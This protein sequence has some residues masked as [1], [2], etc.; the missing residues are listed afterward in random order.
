MCLR[1]WRSQADG[2]ASVALGVTK[3]C[4]FISL[5]CFPGFPGPHIQVQV[6]GQA[7]AIF[8]ETPP[9]AIVVLFALHFEGFAQIPCFVIAGPDGTMG[10]TRFPE[11]AK[12]ACALYP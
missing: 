8:D 5:M 2:R 7:L 1:R 9:K 4:F 3:R 10:Q 12:Q 11:G 6:I